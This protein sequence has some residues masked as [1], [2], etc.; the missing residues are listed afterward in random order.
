MSRSSW[1][2]VHYDRD[3]KRYRARA[4]DEE[5]TH[6]GYFET[7]E[8]GWGA[9][10]EARRYESHTLASTGQRAA[11]IAYARAWLQREEAR[12]RRGIEQMRSVVRAH[13]AQA[14]FAEWPMHVITQREVQR[15]VRDLAT[16]RARG[17][18]GKG[19]KRSQRTVRNIVA[20]LRAIYAAAI[21]D[22][23]VDASPAVGLVLGREER[24]DE[25]FLLLEDAEVERLRTTTAIPLRSHSAF[26][27][28]CFGGLRPGE[29]WGLR[30]E[31]VRLAGR[32]EMIVRRSRSR[33]TKGGKV[34][35][36]PLLEP[37]REA[38]ERWRHE[39]GAPRS[40]LV[41]P[42][43]GG[44]PHA[45]GYDAGWQDRLNG[46]PG[47]EYTQ[48]GYRWRAGIDTRLPLK[49]L[50]HTCACHLLRGT[51]VGPGWIARELRME[52]VSQW[53]G[54]TSVTVTER[55]YA[56][57]APGGLLDVVPAAP[58]VNIRRVK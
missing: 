27:V 14:P 12:G 43:S 21:L 24:V 54:H 34:R 11:L 9:V 32:A 28:A 41:W 17:P 38:L 1:G 30:W 57:L 50:R 45:A 3:K 13:I 52:E 58:R 46:R 19:Q 40:G 29:L 18:R 25:D 2:S 8:D 26:L 33:G 49:D 4:G 31:D 20:V 36:V 47:R 56:R 10:A 7:E 44:R 55:F 39:A 5:R 35:R 6:L 37:A 15:W 16:G 48:L 51:W 22:E 42:G 23:V 53:L